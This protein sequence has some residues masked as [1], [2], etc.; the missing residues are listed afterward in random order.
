M[1]RIQRSNRT[2][3]P[4]LN[5]SLMDGNISN[6][7]SK[8]NRNAQLGVIH[9]R[10][11]GKK[12][13]RVRRHQSNGSGVA[14]GM[15][16]QDLRGSNKPALSGSATVVDERKLH[17]EIFIRADGKKVIR[18]AKCLI[19]TKVSIAT[20][21]ISSTV[22]SSSTAPTGE[23]FRNTD[24]KMVRRVKRVIIKN[25]AALNEAT[26]KEKACMLSSIFY[27][28]QPVECRYHIQ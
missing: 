17:C 1:R 14:L 13:R 16:S 2:I 28:Q 10:P 18:R 26:P 12:V 6:T 21:D 25:A 8:S 15:F 4:S 5:A 22:I 23:T 9:I 3:D 19:G 7:K 27:P 24:G 20:E 11:D